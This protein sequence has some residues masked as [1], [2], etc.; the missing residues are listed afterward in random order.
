M[1]LK[2]KKGES[3]V[4]ALVAMLIISTC[5][6]MMS[7][8]VVSAAKVNKAAKDTKTDLN[9]ADIKTSYSSTVTITHADHS[10]STVSVTEYETNSEYY[11]YE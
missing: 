7:T 8:G 5:F 2:S 6:V 9:T 1:K 3:I 4:E 10:S 11:Y